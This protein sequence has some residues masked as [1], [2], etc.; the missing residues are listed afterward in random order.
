MTLG[1]MKFN[2]MTLGLMILMMGLDI[3]PFSIMKPC[4]IRVN[5]ITHGVMTILLRLT[6]ISMVMHDLMILNDTM[7]L[8]LM[9]LNTMTLGT[10]TFNTMAQ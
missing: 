8:G 2:T 6:T 5:I 3:M 7:T 10:M 4:I 9:K 1:I